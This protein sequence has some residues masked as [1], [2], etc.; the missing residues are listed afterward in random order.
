MH[1][2][3]TKSLH[4]EVASQIRQMIRDGLLQ[5]GQKIDETYLGESMGVSRTPVRE[6][7]RILQAEGL[8]ELIPHKGSYVSQPPPDEI[9]DMFDVMGVLEGTCA[10]LATQKMNQKDFKR[11]EALHREL[12]RHYRS[13]DHEAYLAANN[14]LHVLIQDLTGNKILK[15]VI[16]GLRRKILLY[17][18][19]QLYHLDRFDQSIQEHRS[20]LETF[21]KREELL[22][23]TCMKRHLANQC[24]AL[25]ELYPDTK[26]EGEK[27]RRRKK[28]HDLK[29]VT[30]KGVQP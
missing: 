30:R 28:R 25:L 29:T 18:H 5:R 21:R 2:I 14:D 15:E 11:I 16:N 20:I 9:R 12:E 8:V 19:R 13:R 1:R 24:K 26:S 22:A 27:G 10:R 23:E 7:L 4:V 3:P 6:S 17:R